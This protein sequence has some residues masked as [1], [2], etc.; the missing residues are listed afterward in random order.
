MERGEAN[1]VLLTDLL[2][3]FLPKKYSVVMGIVVDRNGRP[4]R[5]VDINVYDSH[6]H[7]DLFS[8]IS[9]VLYPVDVVYMTIE[10][11]SLGG[12]C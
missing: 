10:L 9:T 8:Q 5:Q 1:E 7:P 6:F 2:I 3:K 11:K 4:S 12:G